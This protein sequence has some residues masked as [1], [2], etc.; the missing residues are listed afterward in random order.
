[1][2]DLI[3]ITGVIPQLRSSFESPY[4]ISVGINQIDFKDYAVCALCERSV[5][6]VKVEIP[7]D[8]EKNP[9]VFYVKCHGEIETLS[10]PKSIVFDNIITTALFFRK[11]PRELFK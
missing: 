10:L 11:S 1:M 2:N 4:V 7:D 3:P 9:Y 8:D 6:E 5:D